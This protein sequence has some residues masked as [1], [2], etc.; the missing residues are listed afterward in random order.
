MLGAAWLQVNDLYCWSLSVSGGVADPA[1]F[2]PVLLWPAL[3]Q[4]ESCNTP[5][6]WFLSPTLQRGSIGLSGTV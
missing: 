4:A 3:G 5:A 2:V 6:K 1:S